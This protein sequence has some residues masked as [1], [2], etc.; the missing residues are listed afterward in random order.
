[1]EKEGI[2]DGVLILI[3]ST[4]RRPGVGFRGSKPRG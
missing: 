3:D 1:M 4:K 2:D